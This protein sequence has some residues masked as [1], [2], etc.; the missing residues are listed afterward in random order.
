[1]TLFAVLFLT[2]VYKVVFVVKTVNVTGTEKYTDSEVLAA[3]GIE[4]GDT[5]YSFSRTDAENEIIL[6]LSLYTLC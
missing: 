3:S 4:E 5:L 1:M 6:P 2:V